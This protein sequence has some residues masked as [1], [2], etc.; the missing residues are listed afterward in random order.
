MG[1]IDFSREC[2]LGNENLYKRWMTKGDCEKGDI[3]FTTE[4]PLGN[5]AQIPDDRKYILSQ[6]VLLIKPKNDIY[7][8]AYIYQYMSSYLFQKEI[9]KKSS[10]TT[11]KG[12]QQRELNKIIVFIPNNINEQRKIAA[13]LNGLDKEI[14]CVNEYLEKLRQQKRGLMQKL[15]TGKIRVKTKN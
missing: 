4:A 6:R 12:I 10:G 9:L 13:V 3:V 14:D 7:D 8:G 1:Y 15:L 11:A 2:Y 5:V